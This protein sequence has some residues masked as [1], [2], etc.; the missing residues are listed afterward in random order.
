MLIHPLALKK[1]IAIQ[2]WS[3]FSN[4]R[5]MILHVFTGNLNN[6]GFEK[7]IFL[8]MFLH[9]LEAVI[10]KD[11]FIPIRV[12]TSTSGILYIFLSYMWVKWLKL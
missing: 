5:I 1:F 11:C 8:W 4:L 2:N 3:N 6:W 12:F 10:K 7:K 9:V